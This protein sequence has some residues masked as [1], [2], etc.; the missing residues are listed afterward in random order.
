MKNIVIAGGGTAG[1]ITAL[2][3][4]RVMPDQNITLVESEEVGILGAGE[5][6]TPHLIEFLNFVGIPV[7]DLVQNCDATIKNGIKFTNWNNDNSFYYHGFKNKK[8]V[9]YDAIDVSSKALSAFSTVLSAAYYDESLD[10]INFTK[11]LSEDY[12]VPF[13]DHGDHFIKS[14]FYSLHFNATKLAKRLSEIAIFRGVKKIEGRIVDVI[15]DDSKNISKLILENEEV[16]VDFVFDCTGFHRLILGKKLN[17]KW[18]SYSK[19][20]PVDSALPF[21]I[22]IDDNI[23]PYTEAI[24]MKYGWI[25]KIPLQ[26]RYGC[27]YV[28][29]SSLISEAEAA[30]E[31]EQYLGYQPEYPRKNKGSFKFSAGC[32]EEAWISNCVGIGLSSGFIEPLEATSIF[33]SLLFLTRL[34]SD[35]QFLETKDQ[36]FK[37]E[38]NEYFRS[39][40]SQIV[41]FIYFHYMSEGLNTPFW[42]KFRY[43]K[44][45]ENV[46]KILSSWEYRAPRTEELSYGNIWN[47][48]S[49]TV[50]GD[51]IKKTNRKILKEYS[52]LSYF[53]KEYLKNYNNFKENQKHELK[54]SLTHNELLRKM[55]EI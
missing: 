27:G 49:W 50:V 35:T 24:A 8:E 19:Y 53:Q 6:S 55:N 46:K 9:S 42:E 32:Y 36:R 51:G 2:Y 12:K 25:W 48:I 21:F 33:T 16:D 45:P 28:F 29:D 11:L 3:L 54:K 17:A 39:V 1:W 10:E 22:P 30:E 40:N 41:D 47:M 23:S 15:L 7:Y 43:D 4:N 20:L 34:L 5:G 26:T 31:V 52:M 38:F 13:V 14:G 18:N 37:D 44:A